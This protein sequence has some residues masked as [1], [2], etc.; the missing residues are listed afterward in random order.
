MPGVIAERD[1]C[2]PLRAVALVLK[3]QE[4]LRPA[5]DGFQPMPK[6]VY[7][8]KQRLRWTIQG[9]SHSVIGQTK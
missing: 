1:W 4:L 3:I 7:G 8:R 2:S 5:S 6:F 9:A